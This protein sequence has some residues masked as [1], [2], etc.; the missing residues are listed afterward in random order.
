M[1]CRI[2]VYITWEILKTEWYLNHSNQYSNRYAVSRKYFF[3]LNSLRI[4]FWK[5]ILFRLYFRL[6]SVCCICMW[7]WWWWWR[8]R[9]RWWWWWWRCSAVSCRCDLVLG[10]WPLGTIPQ[11]RYT[12][13]QVFVLRF[14]IISYNIILRF[15]N[16][17]PPFNWD[18]E[19][20]PI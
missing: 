12:T 20:V 18:S 15:S 11:I 17:L 1:G 16:P 13:L 5:I 6:C 10:H 14:H 2:I 7:R 9:S 8:T 3:V 19:L 4:W